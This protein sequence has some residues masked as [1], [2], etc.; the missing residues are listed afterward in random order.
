MFKEVKGEVLRRRE[1]EEDKEDVDE[2]VVY[3]DEVV[4]VLRVEANIKAT[5]KV[6]KSIEN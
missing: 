3:L 1:D 4:V 6:F 5:A 2:E